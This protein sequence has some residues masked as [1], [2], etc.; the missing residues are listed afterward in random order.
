MKTTREITEELL[1][2]RDEYLAARQKRRKT[3]LKA[4]G[5]TFVLA[6]AMLAV[7]GLG[8]QNRV[9]APSA[10]DP[11]ALSSSGQAE[12]TGRETGEAVS[13][14][15]APFPGPGEDTDTRPAPQETDPLP[16]LPEQETRPAV[17]P[18]PEAATAPETETPPAAVPTPPAETTP[19]A[20]PT[21]P[22]GTTPAGAG[23][24]APPADV[25]WADD[26]SGGVDPASYEPW[27]GKWV[28]YT[29]AQAM[30]EQPEGS[31]FAIAAAP[32]IDD[33]LVIDGKTLAEYEAAA[34]EERMLPEKL[35]QLMK[36]GDLLKYGE[37]LVDGTA[38]NGEIW[39]RSLYEER[40]AFY[41]ELLDIYIQDGVFLEDKLWAAMM[42]PQPDTAQ[43]A[44]DAALRQAHG[45]ICRAAG[46]ELA[47]QG[48]EGG[49]READGT[50]VFFATKEAFAGLTF[51]GGPEWYFG[52]AYRDPGIPEPC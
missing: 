41:G 35:A 12:T 48:I 43:Q 8:K 30:K 32:V 9:S 11:A 3:I 17:T 42:T 22:A 13:T 16:T 33:Q 50:F 25:I 28:A 34:L 45:Q 29:L 23:T 6:A 27:N 38:P 39:A 46:E 20:V 52:L 15:P 19:P 4:G 10:A 51:S 1:A 47:A 49:Y 5:L 31:V 18:T 44:Y 40:I 37:A 2:R 26:V 21:P 14:R 36:E 7:F 24:A